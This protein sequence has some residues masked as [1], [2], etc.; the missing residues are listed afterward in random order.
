MQDTFVFSS[1]FKPYI[2]SLLKEKRQAGYQYDTAEYMLHRFDCFCVEHGITEAV[3]TKKLSDKWGELRDTESKITQTGRIS[4]LRQLCLY[5]QASGIQCY[6]PR[7]FS[8]K[9][10]SIAYVLTKEEITSFFEQVD[11]YRPALGSAV[12]LRLSLEYKVLF[13][14]ILCCGLRVSEAR[15]LSLDMVDMK[16]G[17]LKICHS[18]GSNDRLV[19]MSDDLRKL[20]IEYRNLIETRFHITSKWFFPA[21]DPQKVFEVAS[22]GR[23]FQRSWGKVPY[24]GN[25]LFHPTVHSLRHTFVVRRMNQWMQEGI[26]LEEMMPYLSKYLGHSSV[27]DTFYYYHLVESSFRIIR[28]K[29]VS[30]DMIIPEAEDSEHEE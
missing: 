21:R 12:F 1:C 29:D 11:A 16:N 23:Q 9:S 5:M 18:K 26:R 6:I 25:Q 7:S 3:V 30:S 19:Y 24:A 28:E 15:K 8:H 22:I 14:L 20:C 27:D 10:G 4:V 13:R 2:E 17:I